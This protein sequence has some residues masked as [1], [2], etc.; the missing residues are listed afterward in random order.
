[1]QSLREVANA[2][3]L[4]GYIA[5]AE[6]LRRILFERVLAL[7]YLFMPLAQVGLKPA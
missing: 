6:E 4:W 3:G 1:M 2:T 7:V 5:G